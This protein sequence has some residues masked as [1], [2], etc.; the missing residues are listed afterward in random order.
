MRIDDSG[1]ALIVKLAIN[2]TLVA[3]MVAFCVAMA[4]GEA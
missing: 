3:E 1:Q 2:S 4:E